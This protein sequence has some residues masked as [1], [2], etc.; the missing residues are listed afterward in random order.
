[1]LFHREILAATAK[2]LRLIARCYLQHTLHVDEH[3]D[4]RTV[5][6]WDLD[7]TNNEAGSPG[8][9]TEEIIRSTEFRTSPF[10][11]GIAS[12]DMSPTRNILNEKADL[13]CL[14]RNNESCENRDTSFN[15]TI[16]ISQ[17]NTI[18]SQW[19]TEG[20]LGRVQTPPKFRSFEKAKPNSQFHEKYIRTT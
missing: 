15:T 10:L 20:G 19:R 9:T 16:P 13:V 4:L 17:L 1:M 6:G 5:S 3:T 7:S 12:S 18:L 11:S 8:R 2:L 14:L